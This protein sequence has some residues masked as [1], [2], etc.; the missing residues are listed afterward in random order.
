[1]LSIM[2]LGFLLNVPCRSC[3]TLSA[4]GRGT[5]IAG[6]GLGKELPCIERRCICL[7]YGGRCSP[8]SDFVGCHHTSL[9]MEWGQIS[10]TESLRFVSD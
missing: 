10:S 1:M 6:H 7:N 2:F 5:P 9:T 4:F 8:E 3:L